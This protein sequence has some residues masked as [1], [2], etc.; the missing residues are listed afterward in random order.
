M[1]PVSVQRCSLFRYFVI[2]LSVMVYGEE[3]MANVSGTSKNRGI[4]QAGVRLKGS[5]R[6]FG[7]AGFYSFRK[8]L[9]FLK[10]GL[11]KPFD[12]L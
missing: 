7:S 5:R 2:L 11:A 12:M 4:P 1:N 3:L 8:F 9:F 6:G 10:L